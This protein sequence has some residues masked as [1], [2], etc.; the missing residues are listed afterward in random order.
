MTDFNRQ[1]ELSGIFINNNNYLHAYL[2]E[3]RD[4][5]SNINLEKFSHLSKAVEESRKRLEEHIVNTQTE[6][7]A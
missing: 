4:N 1:V 3:C 2:E 5:K 6:K 7:T